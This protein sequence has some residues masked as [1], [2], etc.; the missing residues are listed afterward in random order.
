MRFSAYITFID[1]ERSL[2]FVMMS[3]YYNKIEYYMEKINKFY[4]E[5]KTNSNL[6]LFSQDYL[7]SNYFCAL[8]S[9]DNKYY[10]AKLIRELADNK[11]SK[12]K[13]GF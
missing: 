8:Y 2:V 10:R 11:V 5:N 3:E 12:I 4:E 9:L 1:K 13:A 7:K 6:N